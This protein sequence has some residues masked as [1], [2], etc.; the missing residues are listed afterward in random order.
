MEFLSLSRRR[1]SSRNVPSDE[2]RGETDVFA[3]YIIFGS[4]DFQLGNPVRTDEKLFGDKNMPISTVDLNTKIR[5]TMLC[6]SGFMYSRWVT[7]DILDMIG[8]RP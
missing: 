5:V 3:G 6:L 7:L 1:S 2:E 8:Y 4:L